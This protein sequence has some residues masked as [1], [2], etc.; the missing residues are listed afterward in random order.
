MHF[1]HL[2]KQNKYI[3]EKPN[4][5][6]GFFIVLKLAYPLQYK[7]ILPTGHAAMKLP[8][9]YQFAHQ[10]G[11]TLIEVMIVIAIVGILAAIALLSYQTQVRQA[12]LMTAYHELNSFRLPYQTLMNEGA[13]VTDFGTDG[14][15]MP[16]ST[17]YCQFTVKTPISAS[18]TTDA[19]VCNIQNLPYLQNQLLSLTF[20]A[21]GSWECKASSG[22]SASYLPQACRP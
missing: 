8:I 4:L 21:N 13:R 18:D 15:N 19:V 2:I 17:K 12:H 14:L 20:T 1:A 22:I 16:T 10:S 5:A 11:F 9:K 3:Y 6:F 7:M